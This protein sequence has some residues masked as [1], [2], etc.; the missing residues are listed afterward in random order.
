MVGREPF[1]RKEEYEREKKAR[2]KGFLHSP[3]DS[4]K[5]KF[6]TEDA[7]NKE[8]PYASFISPDEFGI[9]CLSIDQV[10]NASDLI[11]KFGKIKKTREKIQIRKIL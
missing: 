1:N 3:H 6:S 2:G 5:Y 8:D 7:P 9:R 10:K 11:N 4:L